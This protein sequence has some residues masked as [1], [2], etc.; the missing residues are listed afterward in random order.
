MAKKDFTYIESSLRFGQQPSTVTSFNVVWPVA[1][2]LPDY[3]DINSPQIIQLASTSAT[4]TASGAGMR[5]VAVYGMSANLTPQTDLVWL[6]GT[7]PSSTSLVF[8]RVLRMWGAKGNVNVGS[9]WCGYGTFTA[10]NPASKLGNIRPGAGQSEQL[11][12]FIANSQ[13][14]LVTGF[15]F[16]I[17]KDGGGLDILGTFQLRTRE[18]SLVSS[19]WEAQPWRVRYIGS[20]IDK[21]EYLSQDNDTFSLSGPC[22]VVVEVLGSGTGARASANIGFELH[23]KIQ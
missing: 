1:L 4:D 23:K 22:D 7:T 9:V 5:Q 20:T 19:L 3:L 16:S 21:L 15:E 14:A 12:H 11:I 18:Y 10:G 8:S 13:Q 6:N 17:G 2:A